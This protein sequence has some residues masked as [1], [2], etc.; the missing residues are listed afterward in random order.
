MNTEPQWLLL[1][2]D[3]ARTVKFKYNGRVQGMV[4][5]CYLLTYFTYFYL[6][7]LLICLLD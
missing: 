6:L 7:C 4:V 5:N 2:R 3:A 1:P